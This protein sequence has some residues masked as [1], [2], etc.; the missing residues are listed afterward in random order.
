MRRV[1]VTGGGSGIG[2]GI[3]RAF[4]KDGCA[5]TVAG[6]RRAPLEETATDFDMTVMEAD[7]AD[8][9]L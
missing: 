7:V 2:R 9:D 8:E 5:V 4:A 3:A 1:L 6:R